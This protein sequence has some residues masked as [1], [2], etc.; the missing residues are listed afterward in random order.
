MRLLLLGDVYGRP[1]REM[2]REYLPEITKTYKPDFIIANGENAAGG[3]GITEKVAEEL[4]RLGVN[5]IT[6]GNHIWD[7][8]EVYTYLDRENRLLRP[9]ADN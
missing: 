6:S 5:V 7:K 2:I 4:Y 8:K 1:G 9:A 3:F